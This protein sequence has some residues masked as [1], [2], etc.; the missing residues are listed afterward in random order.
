MNMRE[1]K[2]KPEI[3][4]LGH[5]AVTRIL[6]NKCINAQWSGSAEAEISSKKKNKCKVIFPRFA[7]FSSF[8]LLLFQ[9]TYARC[10]NDEYV[11]QVLPRRNANQIQSNFKSTTQKIFG[12]FFFFFLIFIDCL[13][14]QENVVQGLCMVENRHIII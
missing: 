12:I 3:E 6:D 7:S 10:E 1:F 13:E 11:F 9:L 4:W 8:F 2:S 14:T 5:L